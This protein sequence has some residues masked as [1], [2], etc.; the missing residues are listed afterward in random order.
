MDGG[1]LWRSGEIKSYGQSICLIVPLDRPSGDVDWLWTELRS[2]VQNLVVPICPE[3]DVERVATSASCVFDFVWVS[4][5][6]WQV[7]GHITYPSPT[8]NTWGR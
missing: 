6:V 4:E 5:N 2:A 3:T 1:V 7:L 8:G